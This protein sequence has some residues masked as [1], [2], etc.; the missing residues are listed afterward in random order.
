MP[1][2]V[3]G[4]ADQWVVEVEKTSPLMDTE[5]GGMKGWGDDGG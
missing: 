1:V 5:G 4:L 3:G 2:G